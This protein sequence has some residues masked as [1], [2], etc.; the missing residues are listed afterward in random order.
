M[1]TSHLPR[2]KKVDRFGRGSM[3][4]T[5][6]MANRESR[7]CVASAKRSTTKAGGHGALFQH[8]QEV[9]CPACERIR[10]GRREH[11]VCGHAVGEVHVASEA[12]RASHD[13]D[14]PAGQRHNGV[15]M[16]NRVS[17]HCERLPAI[18]HRRR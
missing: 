2:D 13:Q 12:R 14:G 10:D 8:R 4:L 6:R 3:I 5:R 1:S 16:H 18:P 15:H 17:T 9:V 11:R 7:R